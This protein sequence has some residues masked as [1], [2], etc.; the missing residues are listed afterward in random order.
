MFA[1][2][3]VNAWKN[4]AHHPTCSRYENHL[5]R[6][7][8][9]NLCV[10]CTSMYSS[11]ALYLLVFFLLPSFF[12]KNYVIINAFVFVVA[13]VSPLLHIVIKPENKWIKSVFRGILGIGLGAYSGLIILVPNWW[14]RVLMIALFVVATRMYGQIRGSH[15]NIDLCA[16]CPLSK[17]DPPCD[18][19]ENT[20]IK[21]KKLNEIIDAELEKYER[22]KKGTSKEEE[23]EEEDHSSNSENVTIDEKE[24]NIDAEKS[25]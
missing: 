9:L 22:M 16:T 3:K 4:I 1:M 20:A 2:M 14:I 8:K 25:V 6:I 24:I 11:W 17:S 10:G 19:F 18:P 23:E 15:A 13:M 5:F 7:G 21:V 12:Q